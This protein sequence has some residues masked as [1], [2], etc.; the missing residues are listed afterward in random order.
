MVLGAAEALRA[1]A[2]GGGGLVDVLRDIG[3]ADEPDG[4][5]SRVCEDRVDGFLVAVDHLEDTGGQAGLEEQLGQPHRHRGVALGG[6][7]DEGIAA[8]QGGTGLPQRD[9]RGE[10][11]RGDTGHDTERL[12]HRVDVDAAAGALGVLALQQVRDADGELDDL[13][14]ALD[15]TLGVGDGLAV[16]DRQQL[17]QLIGVG[18]D[19]LDELHHHAGAALRVP[20]GPFLLRLDG[21]GDCGVDVGGRRQE[22][23]GLHLTGAR[24]EH[25]GGAG[26]LT[27]RAAAVDEV[28]NLCGHEVSRGSR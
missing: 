10:V 8:R 28:R 19:Q 7:E 3:A 22:H 13:D 9:H 15:V 2:V 21:G 20:R 14:A 1:L 12:A 23:L 11:E 16:L 24:I 4:L 25:V 27:G 6:L 18:V 17:G 5:E 26:G